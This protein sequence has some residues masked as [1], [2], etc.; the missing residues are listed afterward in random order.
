M[1]RSLSIR[2]FAVVEEIDAEFGSGFTVLTGETGAGKSILLDALSLLLGDRF[3]VR[4][5]RPGAER[6]EISAEF[7]LV[8]AA[9]ARAW[10]VQNDLADAQML[11]LRR[12]LDAQARSRAWINGSPATLAQLAAVGEQLIDVH[13]QHAHQ[14]LGRPETQRALLDAFGGFATLAAEVALAW[15]AW[16]SAAE[17]H[18]NGVRDAA[19]KGAERDALA[20]RNDELVALGATADEWAELSLAQSRLAH[21]ASL[22]EAASA[23]EA[24]LAGDDA[25]LNSRLA[26]LVQRLRQAATHDKGLDDIVALIDEARIG[27][28]EAGRMLRLYR[29]RLELDPAELARVEARLATIHDVA[30]KY[31]VRPEDLPL[32]AAD[33]AAALR[34]LSAD[35]NMAALAALEAQAKASFDALAQALS[36]KRKFAAADLG[37]RVSAMMADLAMAGGR[38]EVALSPTAEPSSFG[39]ENVEILTAT[40]PKQPLGPL[41]R[42]ASGGELSRLGLAI[43]VVL[44]DVSTVPTLIFDEVDAG[45]GGAVAAAVGRLL[46]ELGQRRQVLCVTHLPQVAACADAHCR[47]TKTTRKSAVSTEITQLGGAERVEEIARMLGGHDITAKTRAHAKELLLQSRPARVRPKANNRP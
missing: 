45:I 39:L 31:R 47:V 41:S 7:D 30:R 9:A 37:H 21:A 29:E 46:Q 19:S 43:Q 25:A 26:V 36:A 28:D 12:V 34:T 27:I 5:L 2:N 42:V 24:E 14:S 44:A 11:L 13:G 33:T 38:V 16:R 40:H 35:T 10:L 8:D 18:Q 15:R 6:A 22:L 23:G 4:Q 1:L 3:E 20:S 17:R 32:L